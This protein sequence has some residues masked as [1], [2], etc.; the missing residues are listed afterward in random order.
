MI[1]WKDFEKKKKKQLQILPFEQI[2]VAFIGLKTKIT[3]SLRTINQCLIW[4]C[5]NVYELYS[6]AA[7]LL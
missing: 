4:A 7:I 2:F 6:K 3:A 1:F 5:Y